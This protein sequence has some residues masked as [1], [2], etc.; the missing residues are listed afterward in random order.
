MIYCTL[1]KRKSSFLF[2]T[3]LSIKRDYTPCTFSFFYFGEMTTTVTAESVKKTSQCPPGKF[4]SSAEKNRKVFS[5]FPLHRLNFFFFFFRH[6][7]PL[8]S[9]GWKAEKNPGNLLLFF[10]PNPF[11]FPIFTSEKKKIPVMGEK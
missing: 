8:L 11:Y 4:F 6:F 2:P 7:P 1:H 9:H 5:S 3:L 10:P